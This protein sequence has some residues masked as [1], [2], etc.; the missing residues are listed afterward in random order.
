MPLAGPWNTSVRLLSPAFKDNFWSHVVKTESCW[1]WQGCGFSGGY[2]R[3]RLS[4]NSSITA[5]RASWMLT[6]GDIPADKMMICHKC[7]VRR[8]V[9]PDHLFL[10]TAADN[11]HDCIAKNRR[12]I[13]PR[14]ADHPMA[15]LNLQPILDIRYARSCGIRG[16][17]LATLYKVSPQVIC[18]IVKRKSWAHV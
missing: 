15:I 4:R 7:D 14:G 9:R 6:H 17:D 11:V 3:V 12:P 18:L 2:G 8:C 10:G 1:L 13:S 16:V 5:H